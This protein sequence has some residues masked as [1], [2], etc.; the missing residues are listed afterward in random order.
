[1]HFDYATKAI[2]IL[3]YTEFEKGR[4]VTANVYEELAKTL[5]DQTQ[6]TVMRELIGRGLRAQLEMQSIVT[7]QLSNRSRFH[8]GKAAGLQGN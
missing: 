3:V 6:Y 8:P 2:T 5:G 4:I 1:M 7:G